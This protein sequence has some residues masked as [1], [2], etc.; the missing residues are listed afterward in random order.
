MTAN[1]KLVNLLEN[2]VLTD[3]QLDNL[4][5]WGVINIADLRECLIFKLETVAR[6]SFEY[7]EAVAMLNELLK[8]TDDNTY[9]IFHENGTVDDLDFDTLNDILDID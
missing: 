3:E 6:D 2:D 1:E 8:Y 7:R 5:E 9:I 4:N